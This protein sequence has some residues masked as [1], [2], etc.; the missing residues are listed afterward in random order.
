MTPRVKSEAFRGSI[1]YAFLLRRGY[2][3]GFEL[4][5]PVFTSMD[6]MCSGFRSSTARY[7]IGGED[8]RN[9]HV[10]R[11]SSAFLSG[12]S[13]ARASLQ[14]SRNFERNAHSWTLLHSTQIPDLIWRI[15]AHL[16]AT[17]HIT[18]TQK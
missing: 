13:D 2:C 14:H 15:A 11:D 1:I 4:M 9:V 16:A 10:G 5:S 3:H 8:R 6:L 12:V 7:Q 17:A 18:W